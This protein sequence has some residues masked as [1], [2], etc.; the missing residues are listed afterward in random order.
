MSKEVVREFDDHF[1]CEIDGLYVYMR[2]TS[3][4][5]NIL[6]YKKKSSTLDR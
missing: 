4:G 1:I 5:E 2:T 6:I 3:T